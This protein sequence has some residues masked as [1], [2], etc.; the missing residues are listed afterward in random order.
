[1][2]KTG[3][4]MLV[5][6]LMFGVQADA[7]C[8]FE[9]FQPTDEEAEPYSVDAISF[10]AHN[11]NLSRLDVYVQVS[12]ERLSFLRPAGKYR[13]SYEMTIDI[14]DS[15][16]TLIGEKLWTEEV[17]AATFEET[18]SSQTYSLSQR[19][20]EVPPGSYSVVTTL[21]DNATKNSRRLSRKITVTDYTKS[22]FMLS[23]I[24]LIA[25]LSKRDGKRIVVPAVSRNVGRIPEAF[26]IF[27]EVYNNQSLD[28]VQL[29]VDVLTEKKEK[30]ITLSEIAALSPGRNQIFMRIDQSTLPIGEY[31]MYVRAFPAAEQD[32]VA[33][34][35]ASTSRTFIMRWRGIP[36]S[37]KNI[38]EAIDQIQYIAK[39]AETSYIKNGETPEERQKRLIEFWKRKDTN[40]NTPRNE[41]MEEYYAKVEYANKHF[42]HYT[43]GWRTDMGLVFI[44]LGP[45]SNV[46][47]HPFD[48]DSKPYEV[49]AYYDLNQQFVFVD[50]TGF[51]DYRLITPI[52]EVWQHAKN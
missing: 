40:P 17:E 19:S 16:E 18:A 9:T 42:T 1:M 24:L 51:G 52:S 36:N 32:S 27:F 14:L 39:D 50:Q 30:R 43:V 49:W 35:L 8:Q 37:V 34:S 7:L 2:K 38:D 5:S 28:S 47:R 6:V 41:K 31:T 26:H 45:P 22:Q 44:V 20:F 15:A 11:G 10:A 4:F 33:P 12:Y 23:D 21:R 25:K 3:L 13:A 46:D 29:M 48:R